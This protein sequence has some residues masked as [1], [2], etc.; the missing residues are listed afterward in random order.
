MAASARPKNNHLGDPLWFTGE[1]DSGS[2]FGSKPTLLSDRYLYVIEKRPSAPAQLVVELRALPNGDLWVGPADRRHK[3]RVKPE[4]DMFDATPL[5]PTDKTHQLSWSVHGEGVTY[6]LFASPTRLM[7]RAIAALESASVTPAFAGDWID[8][9]KPL[10][11]RYFRYAGRPDVVAVIDPLTKA[12]KLQSAF[13]KALDERLQYMMPPDDPD[14]KSQPADEKSKKEAEKRKKQADTIRSRVLK[15][16]LATLINSYLLPHGSDPYN[17]RKEFAD[18]MGD[19][20][21]KCIEEFETTRD[22]LEAQAEGAADQLIAHQKSPQWNL[23]MSLHTYSNEDAA[24]F[25]EYAG[26]CLSGLGSSEKGRAWLADVYKKPPKWM[27]AAGITGAPLP[28]EGEAEEGAES[29]TFIAKK[30]AAGISEVWVEVIP[31]A[32]TLGKTSVAEALD[33]IDRVYRR[34]KHT[35]LYFKH[36]VRPHSESWGLSFR[37]WFTKRHVDNSELH[38]EISGLKEWIEEGEPKWPKETEGARAARAVTNILRAVQLL[39]LALKLGDAVDRNK[40][41]KWETRCEAIVAALDTIEAFEGVLK[42]R[43][44]KL[45]PEQSAERAAHATFKFA[46]A[47]AGFVHVA[48]ALHERGEA[49][50]EGKTDLLPGYNAELVIYGLEAIG[51]SAQGALA[52]WGSESALALALEIVASSLCF[53]SFGGAIVYGFWSEGQKKTAFQRFVNHSVF[54]FNDDKRPE[55]PWASGRQFS[56]WRASQPDGLRRQ[57]ETLNMLFANFSVVGKDR[58][59]VDIHLGATPPGFKLNV[60][61]TLGNQ[62]P[63]GSQAYR[64]QIKAHAVID[65]FAT[66]KWQD[67]MVSTDGDV[68]WGAHVKK[69][70]KGATT[71]HVSASPKGPRIECSTEYCYCD[72]QLTFESEKPSRWEIQI[73]PEKPLHYVLVESSA[74]MSRPEKSSLPDP[75]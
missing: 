41:N 37:Q 31:A 13:E 23:L 73:P 1:P 24:A 53:A 64:P 17:I 35:Q 54:G 49:K 55:A 20:V 45:F 10:P 26:P 22:S 74:E 44:E 51:G 70:D 50:R 42:P 15:Y 46:G 21:R 30:A 72:V 3:E 33:R 34:V 68:I 16:E 4:L 12:V 66:K 8:F 11:G 6:F 59:A 14:E 61:F 43:I 60:T 62:Q 40:E 19:V 75:D 47:A 69:D 65:P 56:S 58:Y 27:A 57:R 7:R 71:V 52:L 48:L 9:S 39:N 67:P 38:K 36:V 25:V 29:L 28:P 2:M 18:K 63:P 32:I 5:D